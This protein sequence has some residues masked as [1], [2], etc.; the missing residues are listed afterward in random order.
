MLDYPY[1]GT[2]RLSPLA[3]RCIDGLSL[4]SLRSA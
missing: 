1:N 3:A 4:M 2:R